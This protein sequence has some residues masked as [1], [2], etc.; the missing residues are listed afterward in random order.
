MATTMAISRAKA[1]AV[2]IC[3]DG[4]KGNGNI[5]GKKTLA[6]AWVGKKHGRQIQWR[7]FSCGQKPLATHVATKGPTCIAGKSTGNT[8]GKAMAKSVA[9]AKDWTRKWEI[10]RT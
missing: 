2:A 6:N 4:G 5:G 8:G 7:N 10:T 1:M 9:R 3:A